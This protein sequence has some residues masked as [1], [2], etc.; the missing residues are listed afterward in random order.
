MKEFHYIMISS[1]AKREPTPHQ[2]STYLR[3]VYRYLWMYFCVSYS[4]TKENK[5]NLFS[6]EYIIVVKKSV[7]STCELVKRFVIFIKNDKNK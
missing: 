1:S 7:L 5:I 6:R 4:P 2:V 3:G